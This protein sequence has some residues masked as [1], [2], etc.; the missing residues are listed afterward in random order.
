MRANNLLSYFLQNKLKSALLVRC[1]QFCCCISSSSVAPHIF[2]LQPWIVLQQ[3][4]RHSSWTFFCTSCGPSRSYW[5]PELRNLHRMWMLGEYCGTGTRYKDCFEFHVIDL[6]WSES[7]V[8]G[9]H[10]T[11]LRS[12]GCTGHP[13]S[14]WVCRHCHHYNAQDTAWREVSN[15]FICI[16]LEGSC[17]HACIM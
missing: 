11:H 15:V 13:I 17:F 1:L 9:R 6:W 7:C 5:E 3:N 8:V 16:L 14:V 12:C 2:L 4:P 10:G